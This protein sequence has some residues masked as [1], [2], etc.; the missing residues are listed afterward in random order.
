MTPEA[1]Y[2]DRRLFDDPTRLAPYLDPVLASKERMWGM[3][4]YLRGIEWNVVDD[5][6][7]GHARIQA[8]VLLLWGEDDVTFPVA[9]GERMA[10]QFGGPASFVRIAR[11]SLMPHEERP[12]A[13]LAS[14]IP[15]LEGS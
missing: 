7:T 15:F 13:V 6:R 8:P 1:F 9:L 2:S 10:S 5:L 14:L 11:A 3:L 4:G 12:E